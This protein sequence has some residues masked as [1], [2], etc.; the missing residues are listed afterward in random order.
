ML[1]RSV[2]FL[3]RLDEEARL[4]CKKKEAEDDEKSKKI[5][6]LSSYK[7]LHLTMFKAANSSSLTF[8]I[9]LTY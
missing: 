3:T 7:S 8:P 4:T 1:F 9:P 5:R 2:S 6:A